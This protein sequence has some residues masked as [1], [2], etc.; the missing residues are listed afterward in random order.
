MR[1]KVA[2]FS[3]SAIHRRQFIEQYKYYILSETREDYNLLDRKTEE[4]GKLLI[5]LDGISLRMGGTMLLPGTSWEIREGENWA[6][7][8]SNGSGKSAL[9]RAIKG[10]IPYVRGKLIRHDPE[11]AGIRI[12]YVAFELQEEILIREDRHE[13]A[14]F[15]GGNKGHAL[16]AG[17]MLLGDDEN[18]A[19]FDRLVKLL[20]L[21]P[22]LEHGLRTLSN[23]EFRKILIAR[24][25]LR[26]PK[27]LILDDPFAGLDVGSRE[28][29][30]KTVT[31]LMNHGTQMI[32]VTQ[33]IEE[34][35]AGISHVLLIKDGRVA[36][37]G[38]RCDVIT[39]EQ[40]KSFQSV[41]PA[42]EKSLAALPLPKERTATESTTDLLVEMK[43]ITVAYGDLVVF[44]S[45]DWTVR[46]GENWAVVGP[47]GSGKTTLLGMI[48]GDNLQAYAN[49]VYLFGKK[50]GEGESIWDIRR[51]LGVVSPELQLQ[52]RH[53]IPAREVI[54]SGFFDSIGL[55]RTA[56]QAQSALA[57]QW[58]EF[59]GIKD[60]AERPFNRLSYGEKRLILIARA[61]VKLPE[62][63][64]L[65]EPCQGLDRSNRGM[66]LA[67]MQSI[68]NGGSTSLIYITHHQEELIPCIKHILKLQKV[69]YEVIRCVEGS[70][71]PG[72]NSLQ[73]SSR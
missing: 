1:K 51:R 54:L 37:T 62:L 31:D 25:L 64:I 60:R 59:L 14:R 9:A 21:H 29:L 10:D 13:E 65:D 23:G 43:H 68:G 6:I 32:L 2:I 63:L 69:G 11:A 61:M 40:M 72:V 46:R 3:F 45:L 44:K 57:D 20:G 66:V 8:G 70:D 33:R 35:I 36:Q 42:L 47:N 18:Q 4:V 53:P 58:L 50:R 15:F 5:T 49:E 56:T 22:L 30:V 73:K 55:Y 34:V 24:A 28:L 19:V 52:Y 17:E 38:R 67:L 48:T 27:L 39:P 41:K 26:S 16:T 7:L 71:G 12:G